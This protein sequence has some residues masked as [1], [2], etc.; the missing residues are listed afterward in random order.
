MEARERRAQS[1]T[2][3][4]SGGRG[5]RLEVQVVYTTV[6]ATL[7]AL[8]AAARMALEVGAAIHLTVPQVVPYPRAIDDPPVDK[9]F[10]ER[11]FLTLAGEQAVDTFVHVWLCRDAAEALGSVL[12]HDCPVVV[13][14]PGFRV[15]R[16]RRLAKRLSA[17]GMKVLYI[18]V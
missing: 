10:N 16:E 1:G 13:A 3:E 17:A 5:G 11:R 14:G 12:K 2:P 7:E 4:E 8:K 18:K 6:R 9:R 15:S